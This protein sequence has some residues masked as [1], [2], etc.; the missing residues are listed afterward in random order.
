MKLQ[1]KG[2]DIKLNEGRL[3]DERIAHF[4]YFGKTSFRLGIFRLFK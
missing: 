3:Y 1:S 2:K 4:I